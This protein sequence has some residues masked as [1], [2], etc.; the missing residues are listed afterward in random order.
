MPYL[1]II[2]SWDLTLLPPTLTAIGLII[3][4]VG[5]ALALGRDWGPLR[6]RQLTTAQQR[7]YRG[8]HQLY[9][10]GELTKDAYPALF[11]AVLDVADAAR[12]NTDTPKLYPYFA[13]PVEMTLDREGVTTYEL[14]QQGML[15]KEVAETV[16]G[17]NKRIGDVTIRYQDN[18]LDEGSKFLFSGI[19]QTET[20]PFALLLDAVDPVVHRAYTALGIKLLV[21]GFSLQAVA[22]IL[23]IFI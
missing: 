4:I 23:G 6:N 15:V 16:L 22:T 21:V 9:A 10:A 1:A 5:A 7:H 12:S 8:L 19:D 3:D 11:A 2:P 18:R 20:I 13:T 17:G 14:F